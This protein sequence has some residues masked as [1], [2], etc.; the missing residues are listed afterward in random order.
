ME[1]RGDSAAFPMFPRTF[2]V[3]AQRSLCLVELP[4]DLTKI[5]PCGSKLRRQRLRLAL[6]SRYAGLRQELFSI[7]AMLTPGYLWYGPRIEAASICYLTDG[8]GF[9]SQEGFARPEAHLP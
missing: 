4:G 7:P 2:D 9:L 8:S 6:T 3:E 5:G 1:F